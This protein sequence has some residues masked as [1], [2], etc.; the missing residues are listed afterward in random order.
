MEE[1][2]QIIKFLDVTETTMMRLYFTRKAKTGYVT[3]APNIERGLLEDLLGLIQSFLEERRGY[4]IID[5]DPVV[6][7]DQSIEKCT[8]NYVGNY[9]EVLQSFLNPDN[10]DTSLSPDKL[11]F[12]CLEICRGN[13]VC[14]MY[15]RVTK[16]RRL[17]TKGIVAYF[18][19]NK[20]N[21]MEPQML[22]IDGFV[23][24][25]ELSGNLY[26]MNHISLERI[27][28]LEEKFSSRARAALALLG[29]TGRI[30]NFEQFEEDCLGDQRYHKTLSK[31]LDGNEDFGRAF[32]NFSN[33][34]EVIEMF[35]LD[36]DIE[37]GEI[38]KIRYEDKSQ[39]MDIL[40]IINDA[41]Y[42]SIIRERTGIDVLR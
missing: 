18:S 26:I 11:T 22:G 16:F 13:D 41:Y 10:V 24:L 21:R 23:D 36:I 39:R 34:R 35:N 17:T 30:Y 27:F 1:L 12:Y 33:V 2:N 32:D 14:R 5:Y 6:Y 3:F 19:G 8:V 9:D 29:R 38:P 4:N 37:D 15:R 42:R 28:R 7:Q 20:L 25:I 40:R 31:M